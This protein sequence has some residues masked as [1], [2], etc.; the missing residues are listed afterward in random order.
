[1]AEPDTT[2]RG[3]ILVVDDDADFRELVTTLL[4]EAGYTV[5]DADSG[6]AA[7]RAVDERPPTLVVLDV[8][9]PGLSGYEVCRQL[10]LRFGEGLP[11]I[12]L[13]GTRTE[14]FDRV[15]GLLIGAD[16]YIVKPFFADELIARIQR[17]L[18]RSGVGSEAANDRCV[19]V[20]LT[21]R[22]QRVLQLLAGGLTLHAIAAELH[23][24]GK[25]VAAHI[26][27]ILAKLDVHSR[28]EAVAYAYRNA[29]VEV[30][31]PLP[32]GAA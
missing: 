3:P 13:S 19:A 28:A 5:A 2:D 32:A 1:M 10:R 14:P 16:D 18:A 29:L 25:T 4:T 20:G 31:T 27:R 17:L 7:L 15:G 11:V 21:E 26:Q 6:E 8:W 24:S 23:I 22:E 9:L 12:F 30:E